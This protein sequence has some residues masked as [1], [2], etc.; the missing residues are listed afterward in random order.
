MTPSP[1]AQPPHHGDTA[2]PC[3]RLHQAVRDRRGRSY[4]LHGSIE[5]SRS[6][7]TVHTAEGEQ[8]GELILTTEGSTGRITRLHLAKRSP[9]WVPG[10]VATLLARLGAKRVAHSH[11]GRG[12]GS[13]L[14]LHALRTACDLRLAEVRV[15]APIPVSAHGL[16]RNLGFSLTNESAGTAA[17]YPIVFPPEKTP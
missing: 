4:M 17:L 15:P 13:L 10:K 8:V 12:L 5:I 6:R 3:V 11:R 1:T 7:F 16:F 9:H 14:V 2:R